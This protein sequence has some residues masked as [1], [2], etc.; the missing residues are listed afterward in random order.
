MFCSTRLDLNA[1]KTN[2][3]KEEKKREMICLNHNNAGG[4]FDGYIQSYCLFVCFLKLN[5]LYTFINIYLN[6]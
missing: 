2:K 5:K 4:R 3:T 6:L 1:N